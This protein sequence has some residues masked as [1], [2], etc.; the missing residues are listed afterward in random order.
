MAI[1]GLENLACAG[2]RDIVSEINEYVSSCMYA[3]VAEPKIF[4]GIGV[5]GVAWDLGS[6]QLQPAGKT[7]RRIRYPH[8]VG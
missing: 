7:R 1:E 3:P 4:K 8:P 6:S 5:L 2:Q